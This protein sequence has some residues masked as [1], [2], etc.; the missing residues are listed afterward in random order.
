MIGFLCVFLWEMIFCYICFFWR[1]GK[2]CLILNIKL[3]CN[4]IKFREEFDIFKFEKNLE[5]F[6][7]FKV[8]KV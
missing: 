1:L 2:M 7:L 8:I 3:F 5:N 6:L 4:V